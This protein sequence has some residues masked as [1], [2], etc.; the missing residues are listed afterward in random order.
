MAFPIE[1]VDNQRQVINE[2]DSKSKTLKQVVVGEAV[3]T[4]VTVSP[5]DDNAQV[6]VG[7][8]D[9]VM[10]PLQSITDM[11]TEQRFKRTDSNDFSA[12]LEGMNWT[13]DYYS[14]Y[15][16]KGSEPKYHS[17][18]TLFG[19]QQYKRIV[20]LVLK[21]DSEL[22]FN[23]NDEFS[24]G[25]VNGT[26]KLYSFIRPNIGDVIVADVG[27]GLRMYFDVVTVRQLSHRKNS[28][29][30]IEY[31]ARDYLDNNIS[32]NLIDKSIDTV[33]FN[34]NL[35][36]LGQNPLI[37][38]DTS[39]EL[40]TLEQDLHH[41]TETYYNW[42]MDEETMSFSVPMGTC[43][44]V[45]DY[46][47]ALFLD[48][49]INNQHYFQYRNVR[50]QQIDMKNKTREVSIWD[51]LMKRDARILDES[52]SYFHVIPTCQMRKNRLQWNISYSQYTHVIYPYHINSG[53]QH[54][55]LLSYA[56]FTA[57]AEMQIDVVE[58]NG[59]NRK[60]IYPIR[61][62]ED[63]V[64]S[65]YFYRGVE[66]DMSLIER[67]VWCYLHGKSP[68][69]KRLLQLIQ[70][71]YRWDDLERYYYVPVLILLGHVILNGG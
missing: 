56:Q 70:A 36:A 13:V 10:R 19:H 7:C 16:E 48:R 18:D 43:D 33:Y 55:G 49:L 60:Y 34:A 53:R 27:D 46:T 52:P 12:Y 30:E 31:R 37:S 65:D 35:L 4:T 38:Q 14:Q 63:Y 1:E 42:F 68:C 17:V 20:G 25:E 11:P 28:A 15:L 40:A 29:F 47:H 50:R 21:V 6:E 8:Q 22:S 44:K 45:Y 54:Q 61:T 5:V 32:R 62:D 67:L 64:F 9:K 59:I 51:A 66:R 2:Q 3:N 24:L 71:C 69:K 26:A 58:D 41:L 57:P 39:T 23:Y